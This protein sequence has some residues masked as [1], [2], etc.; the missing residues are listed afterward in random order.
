MARSEPMGPPRA[1]DGL[2]LA[3]VVAEFHASIAEEM[4]RLAQ[5]RAKAS[6]FVAGPVV[7]VAG[8]FDTPLPAEWLLEQDDVDAVVVLGAIV[9]GETAHDEV[10]AHATAATLQ[11]LAL[12]Y[13][14]PVGFAITG[15]GMTLDQAKA[16]VDAGARAVDAVLRVVEAWQ[17]LQG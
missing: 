6:G 11:S 1:G 2:R 15:P 3:F 17:A 12:E 14:K 7:R 5:E 4:L 8:A 9:R 10:I 16:R 13:D